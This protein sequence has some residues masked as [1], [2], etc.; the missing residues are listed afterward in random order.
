M[1]EG[2]LHAHSNRSVAHH[3]SERDPVL[4]GKWLGT[5]ELEK[6]RPLSLFLHQK[7]RA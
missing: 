6:T 7:G 5:I 2:L 4:S 3:R 1:N